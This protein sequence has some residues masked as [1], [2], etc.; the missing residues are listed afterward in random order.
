[1]REQG[2]SSAP[3]SNLEDYQL[4]YTLE[5]ESGERREGE[6]R[7]LTIGRYAGTDGDGP[8]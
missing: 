5:R 8:G 7:L 4:R 6:R 2:V 3:E 1:M